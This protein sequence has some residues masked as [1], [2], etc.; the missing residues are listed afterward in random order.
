MVLNLF[1]SASA[2]AACGLFVSVAAAQTPTVVIREGDVIGAPPLTI[3]SINNPD[4][5]QIDGAGVG[6]STSDG[7]TAISVFWGNASAPPTSGGTILRQEQLGISGYD[8]TGFESF[9]G[10]ADSGAISY[11]PTTNLLAPPMTTGLDSVWVD[12]TPV[13]SEDDP[14]LPEPGNVYRFNSRPNII[15]STG[16]PVWIAGVDNAGGTDQGYRLMRG[17]SPVVVMAAGQTLPPPFGTIINSG[18]DFDFRYSA[19]GSHYVLTADSSSSSTL[20]VYLVLDGALAQTSSATFIG[21]TELVPVASG[22]NGTEAWQNF[23]SLGVNEAG[24]FMFTG[25]TNAA[26]NDEVIVFNGDIIQRE[27]DVVMDLNGMPHTLI[28]DIDFAFMNES[29]DIACVWDADVSSNEILMVNGLILLSEG[30]EVD[31]DGDGIHDAGHVVST[32]GFT[33]LSAIVIGPR[34]GNIARVYVVADIDVPGVGVLEG[35]IC[36]EAPVGGAYTEFCNGDGGD[37]MGCTNCPCGNNAAP[38]TTGGC[39][40]SNSTS[41]RLNPS[42]APSVMADSMRYEVTGANVSTF[43][44]LTSA[45]NQLPQMGACPPGSGL[46]TAILDGLRCVGGSAQRHGSRATDAMGDIGVTNNGWGPPSGP[47]G[48]LIAQGGF[49]AG[50]TRN[51]QCFY[52]EIGTL[53]CMTGQNTTNAV[54]VTFQP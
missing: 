4:V 44:V 30:D 17:L 33:G 35:L 46:A 10:L 34:V 41:A 39:L 12:A 19:L 1:R 18:L 37:Q 53:G 50:Q 14:F 28:A 23:D 5:N 38:G 22:G 29:G 27:G 11:G 45:D 21:Q 6:L 26:T 9:W 3:T 40:N 51:Y 47:A 49:V 52:R 16:E 54:S 31:W 48:G 24:D 13:A 8:Q 36:I 7:V 15:K 42:G 32:N 2:L 25:D 20:G 43:G